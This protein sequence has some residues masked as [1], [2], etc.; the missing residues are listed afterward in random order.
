MQTHKLNQ[1]EFDGVNTV[2]KSR[3]SLNQ[4]SQNVT[5]DSLIDRNENRR[6]LNN[7]RNMSM[8]NEALLVKQ[9]KAR[10]NRI[11]TIGIIAGTTILILVVIII[12][13]SVTTMNS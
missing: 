4:R 5:T 2:N 3:H 11:K 1:R 7:S 9:L 13:V 8:Q 12:A 6:S 10:D